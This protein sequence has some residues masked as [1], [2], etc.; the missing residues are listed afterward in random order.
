[1]FPSG[2]LGSLASELRMLLYSLLPAYIGFALPMKVYPL[3]VFC[4]VR[5]KVLGCRF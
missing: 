1:M 3:T 5:H 4:V 2:F